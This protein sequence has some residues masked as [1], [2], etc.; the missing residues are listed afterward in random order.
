M[1]KKDPSIKLIFLNLLSA[2]INKIIPKHNTDTEKIL[3]IVKSSENIN[4]VTN[5]TIRDGV[6]LANG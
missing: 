2:N 1:H 5:K 3:L 4:G 6:P